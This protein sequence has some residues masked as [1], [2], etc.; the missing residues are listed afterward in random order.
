MRL[1]IYQI[2][3]EKDPN[4]LRVS[5]FKN[6]DEVNPSMYQKVFD[7]EA[8]VDN[9][10]DAFALFNIEGHPLLNGRSMAI[11]D[12]IV[13][14][15]GAFYCDSLGFRN[16]SFD[17]SK[18]DTSNMLRVLFVQP[19]EKP[20]EAEIPDTL[21]AKQK[22]VG[23]YIEFVYNADETALVCDEEAKLKR[24]EGNRYLDGGGIV[25]GNFLVVGLGE[26]DCRSLTDEEI[27][28][29]K[30]KYSEAPDIDDEETAADVGFKFFGFN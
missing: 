21:E 13:T 1:K 27:Q 20:F 15:D 10:E 24:K 12:V 3:P 29:Y 30:E 11:S 2:D 17:E 28:K 9:L 6:I 23:G 8:N 22:A 26:E 18:V 14:D 19:H 5:P 25:A 4:S 16:I 7:A